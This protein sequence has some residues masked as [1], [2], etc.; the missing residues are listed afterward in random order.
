MVRLPSRT[1]REC[2]HPGWAAECQERILEERC[3]IVSTCR[4]TLTGIMNE[5]V[6][7]SP[8]R[9]TTQIFPPCI[10]I[11]RFEIASPRPVP[12]FLRVTGLSAL[13]KFLEQLRLIGLRNPRAGIAHRD[14]E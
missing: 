6:D 8:A 4:S 9:D 2:G 12:P 11:M 14:L 5:N 13:L 1:L 3:H 7:P 10:S